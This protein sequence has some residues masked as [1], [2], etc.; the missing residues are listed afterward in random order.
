M[1]LLGQG[2]MA[3]WHEMADGRAED[4]DDWHSHQHMQE[5]L[6]IPGFLRGRRYRRLEGAPEYFLL[7]EVEDLGVLT[8]AAY[9]ERLN[10]PTDWTRETVPTVLE[11]SRNL[12]R[13]RASYGLG[14]GGF[15][16]TIRLEVSP[17]I[18]EGFVQWVSAECLPG[19]VI[20][21]G[22]VA[23]HVLEID[24]EASGLKTA[25]KKLR[26]GDA[27]LADVAIIVEGYGRDELR[28]LSVTDL[29]LSSAPHAG[30]VKQQPCGLYQLAHL[31]DRC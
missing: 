10:N 27:P 26:A 13:V 16:L 29:S 1:S 24:P 22:V 8:S 3:S 2:A 14:V 23:A 30:A 9:M 17:D 5:R 25:E 20:R 4:H 31:L 18:R 7:Y 28:E 15:A 11:M 12:C 19:L 21:R 6:S